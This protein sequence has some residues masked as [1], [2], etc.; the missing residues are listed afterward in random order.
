MSS[1]PEDTR[2]VALDLIDQDVDVRCRFDQVVLVK[3]EVAVALVERP[4]LSELRVAE[5]TGRKPCPVRTE[6]LAPRQPTFER[7]D[8]AVSDVN[9]EAELV[10]SVE[11]HVGVA[12]AR[13][14]SPN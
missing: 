6:I 14:R 3:L 10:P 9:L 7:G 2:G 13:G 8:R 1:T 11:R 12:T 5:P 4:L